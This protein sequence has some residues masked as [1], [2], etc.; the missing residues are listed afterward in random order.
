MKFYLIHDSIGLKNVLAS[1]D[2]NH[3]LDE[4]V[5]LNTFSCSLVSNAIWSRFFIHHSLVDKD[6]ELLN[7][8]IRRIRLFSHILLNKKK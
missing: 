6:A 7:V 5:I 3:R 2:N 4:K 1:I 8:S